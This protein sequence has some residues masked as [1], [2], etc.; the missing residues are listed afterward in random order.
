[1][2]NQIRTTLL[3]AAMT[4]LILFIGQLLGGRQGMMIALILAAG[5]NFFSYWYSDKLVLKMY[6]AQE[7][8]P[9]QA[10]DLYGM[11]ERLAQR[12]QLPMP[13]VYLIPKDAPNAFATGRNPEH[14]V[15]AVTQGLLE[16]MAPDEVEGVLAHE[17]AHVNNRDILIGSIA[18]TLAGAIMML[19]SMARWG[20]IFG[21]YRGDDDEGGG[22]GMIGA[23]ALSIIAPMAAMVIQ[24]AISRSREYLADATGARFAGSPE[25]LA[26]ALEKLG[27]YSQRRP[28][29][30]NAATAHMFIVNPL[31]GRSMQ[32]LFSTHPPI[33][34]RVQRLRGGGPVDTAAPPPPP[35]SG[36]GSTSD[37]RQQEG[38]AFWDRLSG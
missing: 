12:A 28:M 26:R 36:P 22:V 13:K 6:R 20:A 16:L 31:S 35:G 37:R 38:K 3:L 33:A 9:Q 27:A 18:A 30:A 29:N 24:M 14:A 21:G 15:V 10:P 4:A 32:S 34:E 8:T 25:G 7:V 11:V 2:G 19:A 5:M 17:L 1:M 23:L